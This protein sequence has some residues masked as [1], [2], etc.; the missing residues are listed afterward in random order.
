MTCL[1]PQCWA[2]NQYIRCECLEITGLPETTENGNLENLTL[3]VFKEIGINIDSRKVD[4]EKVIIKF[5]RRKDANK[6]RPEKKT[7]LRINNDSLGINDSLC[8]Y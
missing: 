4:R 2:N 1:E 3:K 5:S 8:T 7:S 6:V